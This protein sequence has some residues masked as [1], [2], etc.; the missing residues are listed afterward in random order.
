MIDFDDELKNFEPVLEVGDME[1][2]IKNHDLTDMTDLLRQMMDERRSR[3]Q[4]VHI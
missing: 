2:E 1:D 3:R 4:G